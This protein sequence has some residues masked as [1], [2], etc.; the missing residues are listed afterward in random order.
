MSTRLLKTFFILIFISFL[1]PSLNISYAQFQELRYEAQV[2]K[3][4]EEK[5]IN[6]PDKTQLYQKIELKITNGNLK[7]KKIIIESGKIPLSYLPQYKAGDN[8]YV[9]KTTNI[10]GEKEIFIITDYIRKIPLYLLFLFFVIL[11]IFIGRVRGAF[12]LLGMAISFATIFIYILPSILAGN[13]PVLVAISAS[14]FLIPITF[15]LSHG[16]NGKTTAAVIGTII[17]LILTGVLANVLSDAVHLSGF[18]SEE[19]SFIQALTKG[20]INMK[21]LLLAG[22]IIGTLGV[23]DDITISQSAIVYKLKEANSNMSFSQVW[24]KAMDIGRDHVAS[25][26]NTLVL[27]YTG[28]SLPLLLLFINSTVPFSD[29]INYEILAE[30]IVRTLTGSIGLI[31]AVPIT[32]FIASYFVEIKNKKNPFLKID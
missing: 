24:A 19:S 29:V 15:Y 18:S 21:G 3:I 11:T 32:T 25:M 5:Q 7:D 8:V 4:L 30:E 23:L 13:D 9:V 6:V 10:S 28:A 12:S 17:A 2:I 20:G 27:V 16:I 1:L 22:I 14:V 31:L 26:V